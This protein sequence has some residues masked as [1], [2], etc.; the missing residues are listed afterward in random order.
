MRPGV[1]PVQ[2]TKR[3]L[4]EITRR[5]TGRTRQPKRPSFLK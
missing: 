1:L 2:R 4:K 3:Q 5:V